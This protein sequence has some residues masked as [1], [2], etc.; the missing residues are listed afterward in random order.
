MLNILQIYLSNRILEKINNVQFYCATFWECHYQCNGMQFVMDS[1]FVNK[2]MFFM[3]RCLPISKLKCILLCIFHF[4]FHTETKMEWNE[5]IS[6]PG[7]MM[8]TLTATKK[9]E[10]RKMLNF[11]FWLKKAQ[12]EIYFVLFIFIFQTVNWGFSEK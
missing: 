12:N 11:F 10:K 2:N 1:L 5:R 6:E 4:I 9:E 3:C 8:L 7:W